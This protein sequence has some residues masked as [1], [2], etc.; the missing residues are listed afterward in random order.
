M[1]WTP[2][3]TQRRSLALSGALTSGHRHLT[4]QLI[5]L[6][7]GDLTR[8]TCVAFAAFLTFAGVATPH[9]GPEALDAFL[10]L[11]G[12]TLALFAA[13]GPASFPERNF[14][15]EVKTPNELERHSQQSV[16]AIAQ[17]Q[18]IAEL[19]METSQPAINLAAWSRLTARMSHELRTPLN[20]V[21]GFSELMAHEVFGPLGSDRYAAYARDIHLSGQKLLKSTEDAL[22]ITALLTGS[23]RKDVVASA[24]VANAIDE[25]IKFHFATLNARAISLTHTINPNLEAVAEPQTLRQ[26]MINLLAEAAAQ[27]AEGASLIIS[28]ED[29][30]GEIEISLDLSHA[31]TDA[32]SNDSFSLLLAR[33][34][35]ELTGSR[36][37][38]TETKC[39]GWHAR[40]RLARAA[41]GDF[42]ARTKNCR[43]S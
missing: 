29:C 15:G 14:L 21:L 43:H 30:G 11:S 1:A 33:T 26:I 22:A 9:I 18:H 24:S 27:A 42:F 36:L 16:P 39:G 31:R 28:A 17:T 2:S 41:Q 10:F 4:N 38:E 12:A 40:A 23:E 20:A 6:G 37:V 35:L 25:A 5:N 8:G 34:L 7:K 32:G 3:A 19:L 13:W